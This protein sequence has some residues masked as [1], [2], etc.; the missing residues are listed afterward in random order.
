MKPMPHLRDS[1]LP[2]VHRQR[3]HNGGEQL[4]GRTTDVAHSDLRTVVLVLFTHR[5]SRRTPG[6]AR[7]E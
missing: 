1:L 6:A 2:F 7:T 5:Q 3:A 4:V